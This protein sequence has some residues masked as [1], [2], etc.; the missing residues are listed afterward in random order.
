MIFVL[1]QFPACSKCVHRWD[2]NWRRCTSCPSQNGGVRHPAK[3][4]PFDENSNHFV[5]LKASVKF[6]CWTKFLLN[7]SPKVVL[8]NK[9]KFPKNTSF[10]IQI[11]HN[12]HPIR[13][14]I[15]AHNN[16]MLIA[17]YH[18]RPCFILSI[19]PVFTVCTASSIDLV[20][21]MLN[22]HFADFVGKPIISFCFINVIFS[23]NAICSHCFQYKS[24]ALVE[25]FR[26]TIISAKWCHGSA[27]WRAP[28]FRFL[29]FYFFDYCP[30]AAANR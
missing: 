24:E 8:L 17:E 25:F 23:L 10:S 19:N 30:P 22:V 20:N 3:H 15:G 4:T 14:L 18:R 12:I 2:I 11:T 7:S 28:R 5:A 16:H 9:M 21:M 29:F 13:K 1:C 6:S 26:G 27:E